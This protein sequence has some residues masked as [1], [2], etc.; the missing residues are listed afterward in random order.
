MLRE[1]RAGRLE[2][3][4]RTDVCGGEVGDVSAQ[5]GRLVPR[6]QHLGG[7]GHGRPDRAD[8]GADGRPGSS[9]SGDASRACGAHPQTN[10][11]LRTLSGRPRQHARPRTSLA[12]SGAIPSHRCTG[13]IRRMTN[14]SAPNSVSSTPSHAV[15]AG[16]GDLEQ[17]TSAGSQVRVYETSLDTA[18]DQ[19]HEMVSHRSQHGS[20]CRDDDYELV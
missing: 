5:L 10:G 2:G 18:L 13:A 11:D 4:Q 14:A 12:A 6:R 15:C 9:D 17:A 16:H 8:R 3:N 20:F 19:R 1:E 7:P